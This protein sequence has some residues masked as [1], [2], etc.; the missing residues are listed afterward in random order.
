VFRVAL[1]VIVVVREV[2]EECEWGSNG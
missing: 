1:T 2:A